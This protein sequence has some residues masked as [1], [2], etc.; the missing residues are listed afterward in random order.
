MFGNMQHGHLGFIVLKPCLKHLKDFKYCRNRRQVCV[1]Q[2]IIIMTTPPTWCGQYCFRRISIFL[3][4]FFSQRFSQNCRMDFTETRTQNL[5][6]MSPFG[7]GALSDLVG[8]SGGFGLFGS[9]ILCRRSVLFL[10]WVSHQRSLPD[11]YRLV[12]GFDARWRCRFL[13]LDMY[14]YSQILWCGHEFT[15]SEFPI[16]VCYCY[17]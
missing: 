7:K 1:Y 6:T 14:F 2:C 5:S 10:A 16:L 4:N 8:F 12:P 9:K 15:F 3:Y 13:V 11:F 17:L